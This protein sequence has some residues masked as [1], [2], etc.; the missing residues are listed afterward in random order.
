ML[1]ASEIKRGDVVFL[2][3]APH[4]VKHLE[5]KSPSSRGAVTLYKLRFKNLLNGQKK[6]ISAKGEDAFETIDCQRI[7]VQF[8]YL[9][10]DE[11]YFMDSA[12]FTQYG[13][14]RYELEDQLDFLVEGMTD[15]TALIIEGQIAAIDLPQSVVMKVVDT[16][17][18]MKGAS[19]SS[20]TK[21]ATVESGLVVQVPEY[22]TTSDA[23]KINTI[24]GKFMARASL[25]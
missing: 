1:K 9:D 3:Q 20:R 19:A 17:P 22:I 24:N 23:I 8:S 10:G 13:L 12:D 6:E 18:G 21:P 25:D 14:H 11:F 4:V 5:T 7:L 2:E 15:I 16:A